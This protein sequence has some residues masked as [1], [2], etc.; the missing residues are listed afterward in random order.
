MAELDDLK[1]KIKNLLKL[2]ELFAFPKKEISELKQLLDYI[3]N[4]KVK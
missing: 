4:L 2:L 3:D 1:K